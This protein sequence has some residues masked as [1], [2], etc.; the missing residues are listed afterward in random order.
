MAFTN[1]FDIAG[2][3]LVAVQSSNYA[4][5]DEAGGGVTTA[6]EGTDYSVS[7]GIITLLSA[8]ISFAFYF[9]DTGGT[10]A[11][12]PEYPAIDMKATFDTSAASG[13]LDSHVR[14]ASTTGGFQSAG[15]TTRTQIYTGTDCAV[16]LNR[17]GSFT[18]ISPAGSTLKLEL[19][20]TIATPD[21]WTDFVGCTET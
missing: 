14:G 4:M 9:H 2:V 3:T 13:V 1:I 7:G 5:T 21:F 11:A 17:D 16:G 15:V 18:S 8:G 6:V 20:V 10:L 12:T 19:D